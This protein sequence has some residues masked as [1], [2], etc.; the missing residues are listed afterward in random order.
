VQVAAEPDCRPETRRWSTLG[1]VA[2]VDDRVLPGRPSRAGDRP[3]RLGRLRQLQVVTDRQVLQGEP[4]RRM[5]GPGTVAAHFWWFICVV[6]DAM[7][8]DSH[9][10]VG[11]GRDRRPSSN[12]NCAV[13][14]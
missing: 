8:G 12:Q 6:F 10:L 11:V 3:H 7:A 9:F 5:M 2:V 1:R 14:D 4:R 13:S